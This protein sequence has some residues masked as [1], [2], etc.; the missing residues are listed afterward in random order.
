MEQLQLWAAGGHY[1]PHAEELK[2]ETDSKQPRVAS[3]ELCCVY[4][5][6]PH[7]EPVSRLSV[8]AVQRTAGHN[9]VEL[10]VFIINVIL[11]KSKL[12]VR[13]I[14]TKVVVG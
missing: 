9:M 2:R 12:A 8:T 6:T 7:G 11:K 1:G 13:L 3:R 5:Q 4:T 10:L 14:C